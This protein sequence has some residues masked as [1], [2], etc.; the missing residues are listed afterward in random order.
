[1]EVDG[2]GTRSIDVSD[3][4]V[5]HKGNRLLSFH[6][7]NPE[8]VILVREILWP[9]GSLL[10]MLSSDLGSQSLRNSK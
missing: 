6:S 4:G 8:S 10:G 2:I 1:M 3:S 7:I 9:G 5:I